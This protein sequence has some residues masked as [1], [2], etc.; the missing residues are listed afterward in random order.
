M[1]SAISPTFRPKIAVTIRIPTNIYIL[2]VSE[3]TA[4]VDNAAAA[5]I[6]ESP[7]KNG[8]TTNPVSKNII[9]NNIIYVQIHNYLLPFLNIY[10]GAKN[11]SINKELRLNTLLES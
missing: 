10:Q 5:N 6:K 3:F 2:S 11:I 8:V 1:P 7:G 4:V 9:R